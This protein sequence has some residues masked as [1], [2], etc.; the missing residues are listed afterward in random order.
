MKS[1]DLAKEIKKFGKNIRGIDSLLVTLLIVVAIFNISILFG[2]SGIL[3]E[4]ITAFEGENKPAAIKVTRLLYSNCVDCYDLNLALDEIK[5]LNVEVSEERSLE[6]NSPEA[7][8]LISQYGIGVLP[9]VVITGETKKGSVESSWTK[10]G[11]LKD[12]GTVIFTKQKIPY[13]DASKQA[14]VG[15]VTVTN[16]VDS[17]CIRCIDMTSLTV[18]L[19]DVGVVIASEETLE[20]NSSEAQVLVAK[21]DIQKIPSIIISKD[22]TEYSAVNQ[23]W[24]QLNAVEKDGFYVLH[25]VQPPYR[26]LATGEIVGLVRLVNLID[27]SCSDCYDVSLHEQILINFGLVPVNKTTYDINSTD[28][29][30]LLEKYNIT[31]VPTVLLSPEADAYVGLTQVWPQVGSIESDG[32]YV[33]REMTALGNNVVFKDL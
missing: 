12:D 9:T 28:G 10:I 2:S 21:F 23:I 14:V 32:W 4:K 16:L 3:G 33:F 5:K 6:W 20:Y 8:A 29:K 24:G 31:S 13:Y 17:S 15:L 25:A 19:R 22:V 30:A 7:Q 11:E 27:S 18:S 26:D 1:K